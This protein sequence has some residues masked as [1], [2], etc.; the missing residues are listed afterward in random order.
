MST[1]PL[2][3]AE[4]SA[5]RLDIAELNRAI[6]VADTVAYETAKGRTALT[7]GLIPVREYV[8]ASC[9]EAWYRWPAIFDAIDASV[10]ARELG[11]QLRGPGTAVTNAHPFALTT[12][13]LSG[14]RAS[15]SFAEFDMLAAVDDTEDRVRTIIDFWIRFAEGWRGDGFR[16]CWNAG[17]VLHSCD[18]SVVTELAATATPVASEADNTAARRLVAGLQQFLFLMY[19]D[20]RLGTGDSGPYPL[21]G[22]RTMIIREFSALS[23][24]WIPWS[25]VASEVPHNNVVV[26]LIFAPHVHNRVSDLSTTWSVPTDNL[27]HLEAISVCAVDGPGNLVPLDTGAIATLQAEVKKATAAAYRLVA[28]WSDEEKVHNGAHVYF[29]GIM[30]PL[31]TAAG[32]D[33]SI[34]WTVNHPDRAA[35][36]PI[37]VGGLPPEDEMVSP[38]FPRL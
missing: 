29:R 28:G 31:T 24:S 14:W 27:A 9:V 32:V 19:L 17:D 4:Q 18:Q 12:I 1:D 3:N 2:Y 15:Q 11:A 30:W 25:N 13:A 21:P 36:W 23:S 6:D 16:T 26:G 33:D 7:S 34:D 8:A 22:G 5:E 35:V 37:F 10:D 38:L 20:T